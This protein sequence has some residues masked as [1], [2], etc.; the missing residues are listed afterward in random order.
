M[1]PVRFE[2]FV[3]PKEAFL[4]GEDVV[5]KILRA[6]QIAAQASGYPLDDFQ[7]DAFETASTQLAV[8]VAGLGDWTPSELKLIVADYSSMLRKELTHEAY[9]KTEHRRALIQS[10]H[11]T[12]GSIER[13]HQNISAV[14]M[15][16]GLPWIDGYKPLGNFQDALLH[17]VEAAIDT[18]ALPPSAPAASVP[19]DID[20]GKVL[21]PPPETADPGPSGQL[22]RRLLRKFDPAARDAANRSLGEAGEEFVRR[23][24]IKRLNALGK[25]ALA[26]KVAWVSK[27]VGDGLGHDIK[28]FAD[29][30]SQIFIEVKTTRGPIG[31]P[32]FIS[33]NEVRASMERGSAYRLYRVF[34][35][36]KNT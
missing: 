14:L 6:S 9:S 12:E 11:R 5:S 29:D 4:I 7:S 28:F 18:E 26:A 15:T 8:A 3:D 24:E 34:N 32:F 23:Y 13:K 20:L 10:I 25:S 2:A 31:T 16:L 27:T 35:F 21:V 36:G 17:A 1:A 22:M 19:D 33:P 30:G